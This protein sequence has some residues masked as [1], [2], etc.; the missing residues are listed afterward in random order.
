MPRKSG[1]KKGSKNPTTDAAAVAGDA[2]VADVAVV[3]DATNATGDVQAAGA[4]DAAAQE[5]GPEVS[6]TDQMS[7]LIVD[8]D[9]LAKI[10]RHLANS[11]K[12]VKKAHEKEIKSAEK[13]AKG[14]KKKPRDPNA[15]KRAPS[16]FNKAA[17]LSKELSKFLGL[18][19]KAELSRPDV[20]KRITKYI[21]D[22][23]LQND[24]NKR[25]ILPDK[26]LGKLLSGPTDGSAL[27]FFNL[28]KY[29]K[30]HFPKGT[31]M[32]A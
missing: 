6:C 23:N 1:A 11:M 16:G 15:P 17:P 7:Q 19:A 31:K 4:T 29:I 3:A 21:K 10:T 32:A 20:T 22:N 28:Q 30:H 2:P 9:K 26:K 27:T 24:T 13:V 8:L 5:S 25:E 14:K 18:D 12:K